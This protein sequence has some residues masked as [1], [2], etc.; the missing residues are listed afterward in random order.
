MT[1]TGV[2]D[3]P[4]IAGYSYIGMLGR[5]GFGDVFKFEQNF[6]RRNVAVKVFRTGLNDSKKYQS[7]VAEVNNLARFSSHPGVVTIYGADI[8]ADGRPLLIMEHCRH[9]YGN[10]YRK[11]K[12]PLANMIRDGE[13]VARTLA[14]MHSLGV[15]H[16]DVKP[17]N[18]LV[19]D[20]GVP[21]LSDFGIAINARAQHSVKS[22]QPMSVPW[23]AP[24]VLKGQ[25][26]GSEKSDLWSLGA[27]IFAL[28]EGVNPFEEDG[29]GKNG[30]NAV[31]RRII[32][33]NRRQW[34]RSG[35]PKQLRNVINKSMH[36]DPDRR[37]S[38]VTEFLSEWENAQRFGSLESVA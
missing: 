15:I 25:T 24:E 18:I 36:A 19:T 29:V 26:L 35:L 12:H 27:T 10:I 22:G 14:D 6:P 9:S 31:A 7:F 8:S 3:A 16:R 37:H 2:M 5:G 34:K 20:F 23:T 13:R 4:R 28:F 21:V 30:K 38:S 32:Q 11:L 33:G 17:A 1:L